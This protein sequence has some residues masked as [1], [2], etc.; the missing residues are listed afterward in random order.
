M[1]LFAEKILKLFTELN[2]CGKII[3][4]QHLL[5]IG[6]KLVLIHDHILKIR[7]PLFTLDFIFLIILGIHLFIFGG[8][9]FDLVTLKLKKKS[10]TM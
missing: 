2:E 4:I 6:H 1:V 10:T 5:F 3:C 8:G 9:T 7:N